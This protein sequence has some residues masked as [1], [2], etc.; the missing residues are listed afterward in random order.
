M[1]KKIQYLIN[2]QQ[3]KQFEISIFLSFSE[4]LNNSSSFS[5]FI[6]RYL[7]DTEETAVFVRISHAT[8][9]FMG[10]WALDFLRFLSGFNDLRLLLS[11]LVFVREGENFFESTRFF[12]NERRVDCMRGIGFL[13][14]NRWNISLLVI[15]SCKF[16]AIDSVFGNGFEMVSLL[17]TAFELDSFLGKSLKRD[18]F[19]LKKTFKKSLLVFWGSLLSLLALASMLSI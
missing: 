10:F 11:E 12:L 16:S 1:L 2:F 17:S 9:S 19:L 4:P 5:L 15:F 18:S 13:G 3:V 7:M 14:M 6:V 8:S